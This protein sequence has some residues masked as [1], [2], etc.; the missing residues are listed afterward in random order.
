MQIGPISLTRK[1]WEPFAFASPS[2]ALIALVIIFPLAYSFW[3][4]FRNF[5]LSV[6]PDSEFIGGSNYVEA[7]IRDT[8]FINSIWNTAIIIGPS[9]VLELLVGLGLALLLSR[10]GRGRAM[11]T[12]LLAIPAMVSPV[13]AAMAWRMM[14]GVKYGAINNLGR[15]LGLIDV[16]FDWFSNPFI[17]IV[18]IVLVEVWHNTAFMMLVLLAGLQ[19]I[20]Q[21]L[22]DAGK[23]DGAEGW[24]S[25]WYITL[26]LL[27]FTM[28]VGLMIRLIDLTKLFGLIFVLTFGGPGGAT[29]TVAFSTYLAGFNDFRMSYAAALSYVIVGGVLVLTL[30][31][32]WIQRIREL[33]AA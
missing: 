15:Q 22:Y 26:P 4:S 1:R 5:D 25:F 27:K 9:L 2:L 19:S 8:R 13:M 10:I 33:R 23:A 17:S 14:F 30:V 3:L 20:P 11:I 18:A 12:A 29:E 21:E 6:G 7:L 32:M 16:Y 28:V 24:R 31:F